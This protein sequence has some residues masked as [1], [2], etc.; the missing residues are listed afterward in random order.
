MQKFKMTQPLINEILPIEESG[1]IIGGLPCLT[2]HTQKRVKSRLFLDISL[3]KKQKRSSYYK[4]ESY[5][6]SKDSAS[7]WL[8]AMSDHINLKIGC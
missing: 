7:D 3:C 1:N 6:R 8:T 5:N 2:T 4:V